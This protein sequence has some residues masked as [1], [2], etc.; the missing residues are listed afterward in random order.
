MIRV[1]IVDDDAINRATFATII[2][3]SKLNCEIVHVAEDG[4]SALQ[5][6]KN[7]QIHLLI[8]DIKMPR[9]DGLQLMQELRAMNY[10][11]MIVAIS[12]YNEFELVREAF[13]LGI[14]DYC[15]KAEI[16]EDSFYA[17]IKKLT[18][19]IYS[20][21]KSLAAPSLQTS[22][23][24]DYILGRQQQLDV[25]YE[26]YFIFV[27][28]IEDLEYVKEHFSNIKKEVL[29]PIHELLRQVLIEESMYQIINYSDTRLIIFYQGTQDLV[30]ITS[31]CERMRKVI[32]NYLNVNICIGISPCGKTTKQLPECVVKAINHLS[33][34]YLNCNKSVFSMRDA[35]S[36][37]LETAYENE[38]LYKAIIEALKNS[39]DN[40]LLQAQSEL[41]I[42]QDYE[43][44]HLIREKVLHMIY[45]ESLFLEDLGDSIWNVFWGKFDYF[46]KLSRLF[47]CKE[48]RMWTTNYNRWLCDYIRNKYQNKKKRQ[49]VTEVSCYLE[50][51]YS[52]ETLSL[53]K[54]AK[55]MYLNEYYFSKKFKKEF[56]IS[57][58][59]YLTNLRIEKAKALLSQT[60]LKIYEICA[61]VGFNSIE[62][63]TRVFRKKTGQSPSEYK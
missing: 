38:H 44:I 29:L 4:E 47:S 27:L 51:H 26:N 36:F 16:K 1:V 10:D 62:H 8:T 5:Y 25:N 41:F 40:K 31:I 15:L 58:I 42:N 30:E 53:N 54:I 21:T 48:I 7:H 33:L 45:F 60:N 23:L 14:E 56:N 18:A 35:K 59:N 17:F 32:K 63:F 24:E 52:D 39:D 11:C 50:Q 55:D 12:S 37:Q 20:H 9:M 43:K 3:W 49:F 46:Q 57:Y 28:Q 13:K 2:D 6:L 61:K 19:K 34:K 22:S